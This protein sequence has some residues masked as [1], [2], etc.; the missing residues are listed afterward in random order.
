MRTLLSGSHANPI[1]EKETVVKK[2]TKR[3]QMGLN[4]VYAPKFAMKNPCQWK[5]RGTTGKLVWLPFE[6]MIDVMEF[7]LDNAFIMIT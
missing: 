6:T 3:I 4:G 1:F 5:Y 2:K 7:A